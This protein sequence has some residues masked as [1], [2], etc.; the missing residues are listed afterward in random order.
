[1]NTCVFPRP[2]KN[3]T[4][5]SQKRCPPEQGERLDELH[6]AYSELY[7]AEDRSSFFCGFRVA[8]RMLID[9]ICDENDSAEE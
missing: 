4:P 6:E 2:V 1:M 3:N 9:A 7:A 8:A 5:P